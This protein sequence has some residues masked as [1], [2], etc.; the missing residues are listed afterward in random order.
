MGLS[1]H[2]GIGLSEQD[3]AGSVDSSLV[4]SEM[5]VDL[6]SVSSGTSLGTMTGAAAAS[7]DTQMLATLSVK[8]FAKSMAPS[9]MVAD[10][11]G[12]Y[13]MLFTVF[14]NKRRLCRHA[15]MVESRWM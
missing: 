11:D 12:D 3:L 6:H 9:L 10:C 13:R 8:D 5:A 15:S 4:I 7:V 2:V 1:S 14:H